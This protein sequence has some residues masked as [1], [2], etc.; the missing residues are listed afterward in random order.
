MVTLK[1]ILECGKERQF[2][3]AAAN[4]DLE[5]ACVFLYEWTRIEVGTLEWATDSP[6]LIVQALIG[7]QQQKAEHIHD[8]LNVGKRRDSDQPGG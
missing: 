5:R 8:W 3:S 6:D 4:T 2:Q 7:L 1:G